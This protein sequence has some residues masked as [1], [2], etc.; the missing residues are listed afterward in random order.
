METKKRRKGLKLGTG[1][2]LGCIVGYLT[3]NMQLWFVLGIAIG[4]ALEYGT[5]KK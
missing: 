2:I 4:A 1:I 5:K 3:S